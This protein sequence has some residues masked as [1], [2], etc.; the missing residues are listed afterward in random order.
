MN[1]VPFFN[2]VL[3]LRCSGLSY[4][5]LSGEVPL[6]L[7][8]VDV[9]MI[10]TGESIR[11]DF[12]HNRLTG[13]LANIGSPVESIDA[14]SLKSFLNNT[15]VALN[16]NRLSGDVPTNFIFRRLKNVDILAGNIFDC[17]D[18]DDLP[19]HDPHY[20][21]YS[22][23]SDIFDLTL[24]LWASLCGILIVFALFQVGFFIRY[25]ASKQTCGNIKIFCGCSVCSLLYDIIVKLR[26][27]YS[28]MNK[29][30]G[31][32]YEAVSQ[33]VETL[34]F[35][36]TISLY[37]TCCIVSAFLM[38]YWL[39]KSEGG[40]Y[41]HVHQYRW[42]FTAAYLS[43]SGAAVTLIM[44]LFILLFLSVFCVSRF[45]MRYH[46]KN[47]EGPE[48]PAVSRPTSVEN[49]DSGTLMNVSSLI[50][51]FFLNSLVV[52]FAQGSFV[53]AVTWYDISPTI[54]I[55]LQLLLA[56]FSIFWDNIVV[57]KVIIA[58][59]S[60]YLTSASRIQLHNV[61]IIF[62]GVV[63]PLIAVGFTDPNCFSELIS[64][65]LEISTT[66]S[67]DYCYRMKSSGG[68]FEYVS[69]VRRFR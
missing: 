25:N 48:P 57:L 50:A 35:I 42:L 69:R 53:Y 52:L 21:F 31:T 23:G 64:N 47:N 55:L 36:R 6:F 16:V 66:T 9:D 56:C 1:I 7:Q 65:S 29:W 68:C 67:Y 4:N 51:C 12:S 27:W 58:W 54:V 60:K 44:L 3:Q 41:T 5:R 20:H 49:F 15:A 30:N 10:L 34:A 40:W 2:F 24:T 32:A 13:S 37:I 59:F 8:R 33:F 63:A 43:G 22:C 18:Y 46:D 11:R 38:F 19:Q 61:L 17:E 28:T 14:S 45:T 62:N 26:L 39:G